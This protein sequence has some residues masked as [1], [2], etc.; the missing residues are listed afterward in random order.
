ML[1][2]SPAIVTFVDRFHHY[3]HRHFVIA[4]IGCYLLA[5]LFPAPGDWV[6]SRSDEIAGAN[7]TFQRVLLAVALFI[8]A[9]QLGRRTFS[10]SAH[11]GATPSEC[12]RS[13]PRWQRPALLRWGGLLATIL[14]L[15]LFWLGIAAVVLVIAGGHAMGL[16]LLLVMGM[17][18]AL[19]SVPWTDKSRGNTGLALGLILV[20]LLTAPLFLAISLAV[21]PGLAPQVADQFGDSMTSS[22]LVAPLTQLLCFSPPVLIGLLVGSWLPGRWTEALSP[23]LR[24]IPTLV[25]L[26]L[27]YGYAARVIPPLLHD[28]P[29]LTILVAILGVATAVMAVMCVGNQIAIRFCRRRSDRVALTYSSG[30]YNTGMAMVLA[31]TWLPGQEQIL[32]PIFLFTLGQHLAAAIVERSMEPIEIAQ[33]SCPRTIATRPV[34]INEPR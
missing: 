16:G 25:I 18:A 22:W 23:L 28:T 19:S 34:S 20:T 12:R 32:I 4:L 11:E 6:L 31:A 29:W 30:M 27:N 26:T 17:P 3:V 9:W 13:F 7:G 33:S 14:G 5:G 1:P 2:V 24:P 8:S 21:V 10:S 15:R